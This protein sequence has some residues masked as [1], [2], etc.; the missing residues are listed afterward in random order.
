[1]KRNPIFLIAGIVLFIALG[2][3]PYSY[4][5]L[6]RFFVCGVGAYGAYLTY[7]KKEFGWAWVLGIVALLFNP[8]MKFYFGK[9]AW[10]IA[11]L[12]GG[13]IF[14]VYFIKSVKR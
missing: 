10:R 7:Q 4:Y 11:D 12:I 6:L 3:L 8:F 1:M 5:Q 2:D 9:E 14:I 13:I